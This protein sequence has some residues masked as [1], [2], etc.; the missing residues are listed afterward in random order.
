MV[1]W[2]RIKDIG[3]FFGGLTG[4]TKDDFIDGNAKFVTYMNVFTQPSFDASITGTVKIQKGEKQNIIQRGD[5]LFTGSS[6]TPEEAGMSC[7]VTDELR[8]DYYLNSFCF[9]LRLD[10]PDCFNLHFLKHLLRSYYVRREIAKSAKG[11][12]RFNISKER[13]GKIQLPIPSLSEQQRIATILDTFT[14]SI[15]NLKQR[16]AI[17]RKQYE[18]YR[19]QLLDL[20]GKEGVEMKSL[21]EICR[22]ERGVRVVKRDLEENGKVPVFQNSLTPLGYYKKS[23][24]NGGI[25]FVIAGGAAGDVGY[26]DIPFWAADDCLCINESDC[27]LGKYIYAILQKK[28]HYLKTQV[29]KAGVPRLSRNVVEKIPVYIPSINEQHRIVSLLDTFEASIQ[30]LETRLLIRKKQYEY[31]RDK[32]LTFKYQ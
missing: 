13:F 27:V 9:G 3:Q 4:K 2:K 20:E 19:D 29:R 5:I 21:G 6:E 1:E 32:L 11:V 30:S 14:A 8:E 15:E 26:S 23:N 22:I 28:Q 12:T 31:Y 25:P 7:V 10:C 17:R 18:Y 24:N 16:I